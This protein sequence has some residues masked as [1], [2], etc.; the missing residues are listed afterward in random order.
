MTA[1][2][3]D[4]SPKLAATLDA[5]R[6][7]GITLSPAEVV[8][9]ATLRARCDGK[10]EGGVP[11]VMG[12]PLDYAGVQW[13][14]LH[15]LAEAWWLR[16]NTLLSEVAEDQIAVYLFA[17][18]HSA[19]GDRSLRMLT[20]AA[21]IR[22]AARTWFRDLPL[23][24]GQVVE[25]CNRL[26]ELDGDGDGVPD[27]DAKPVETAPGRD[28]THGFLAVMCKAFPGVPPEYWMSEIPAH[29]ARKILFG[30]SSDGGWAT[31]PE[32]TEAQKN[33]LKAVKWLWRTHGKRN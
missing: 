32:R 11:W 4:L 25:L 23:H 1:P 10:G 22:K 15:R 8:W 20:N 5:F 26:R 7:E 16:A 14:P 12:S 27:P 6:A 9:L 13:W 31:S 28:D 24:D 19:P 17:H 21:A 30:A 3:P 18:A 33:Y 29:D 2:V